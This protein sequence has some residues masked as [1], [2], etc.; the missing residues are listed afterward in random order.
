MGLVPPPSQTAQQALYP[1]P[2]DPSHDRLPLKMR[3]RA[4]EEIQ[5]RRNSVDVQ[6]RNSVDVQRKHSVDLS[7]RTTSRELAR[8][9][10]S[11]SPSEH[12]QGRFSLEI[13]RPAYLGS[14]TSENRRARSSDRS[15]L[16]RASSAE[17]S[18]PSQWQPLCINTRGH[19]SGELALPASEHEQPFRINLRGR[20]SGEV[21]RPS[22]DSYGSRRLRED[23]DTGTTKSTARRVGG[24]IRKKVWGK[25]EK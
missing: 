7:R 14:Y 23:S 11:D 16:P 4:S 3:G 8:R 19:K 15:P 17:Q 10:G 1:A 22:A 18:P 20:K 5:R 2:I 21:E 9:Q 24:W 12:G 13:E 6:R 25:Q